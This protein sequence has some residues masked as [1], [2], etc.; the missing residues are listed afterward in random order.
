MSEGEKHPG[1][2]G[3]AS[4][5]DRDVIERACTAKHGKTFKAL[6]PIE[7]TATAKEF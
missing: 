7:P 2:E 5:S 3:F 4:M 6:Y 1:L